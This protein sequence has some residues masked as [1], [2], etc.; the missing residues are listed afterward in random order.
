MFFRINGW[1]LR[2]DD[3]AAHRF[4][5]GLLDR[6]ESDFDHLLPWIRKSLVRLSRP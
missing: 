3:E 1:M 4:L 2:V 6:G 5:T